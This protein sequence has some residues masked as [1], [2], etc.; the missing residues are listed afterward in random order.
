MTHT[1]KFDPWSDENQASLVTFVL[2]YQ[3][4]LGTADNP[5][6]SRSLEETRQAI[7]ILDAFAAISDVRNAGTPNETRLLK[8]EGGALKV[9]ESELQLLKRSVETYASQ[10]PFALAKAAMD[11]KE[12]VDSA[13]SD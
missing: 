9:S 3:A 11:L 7:H 1:L 5:N 4:F 6:R 2:L 12:F 10:V 8:L 13:T